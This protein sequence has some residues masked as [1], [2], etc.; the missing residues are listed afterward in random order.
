MPRSRARGVARELSALAWRD[1]HLR[2]SMSTGM[3]QRL[4]D[5]A[6]G[7]RGVGRGR[8]DGTLD[9]ADEC[10]P[11]GSVSSPRARELAGDHGTGVL[12]HSEVPLAGVPGLRRSAPL[13]DVHCKTAA[14]DA[15][16]DGLHGSPLVG[17]T[18]P[19][20]RLA[21]RDRA[22]VGHVV[23]QSQERQQRA[24]D[25][26]S[27][28]GVLRVGLGEC[29]WASVP[30]VSPSQTVRLPRA[31][32]PVSYSRQFRTREAVWTYFR[33]GRVT[34]VMRDLGSRGGGQ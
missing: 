13:A 6:G 29:Q 28:P 22:V 34:L 19:Q 10:R 32:R 30:S 21:P 26:L 27:R 1:Q 16:V 24:Q 11:P 20:P 12:I 2:R 25:A 31:R 9:L 18:L 23:V 4:R 7:V 15:E 17:S 3:L 8:G 14:V 5:V 33:W